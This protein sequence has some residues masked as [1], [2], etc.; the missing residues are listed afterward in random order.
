ML[1]KKL[2]RVHGGKA[3]FAPIVSRNGLKGMR[4][5]TSP[6]GCRLTARTLSSCHLVQ[7]LMLYYGSLHPCKTSRNHDSQLRRYDQRFVGFGWN[8]VSYTMMLSQR[9]TFAVA[10]HA[11]IVH[12]SHAAS[13]DL[14]SFR[15]EAWYKECMTAL[16]EEWK[17]S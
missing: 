14:A 15:A 6:A 13:S 11:F 5:P 7:N 8:K 10:P 1:P 16:L 3:T 17:R 2:W 9:Y 12:H 4:P